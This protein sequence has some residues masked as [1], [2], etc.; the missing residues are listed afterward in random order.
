VGTL[1]L[2]GPILLRHHP[3]KN[4]N[5]SLDKLPRETYHDSDVREVIFIGWTQGLFECLAAGVPSKVA[6]WR[7]LTSL[8]ETGRRYISCLDKNGWVSLTQ[9]VQNETL[10]DS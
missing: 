10:H 4:K 1:S 2:K 7:D 3:R 6:F 5:V 9:V 8:S